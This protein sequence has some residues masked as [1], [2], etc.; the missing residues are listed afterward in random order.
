MNTKDLE[1]GPELDA[2]VAAKVM[3]WKI[4]ADGHAWMDAEL[5][6]M[7]HRESGPWMAAGDEIWSPS[8]D[9]A[10]A[11]EVWL[12]FDIDDDRGE[13]WMGEV[14]KGAVTIEHFPKG[15][16]GKLEIGRGDW[17]VTA[18]YPLAV[19]RAALKAVGA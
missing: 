1:G 5:R 13:L 7:A 14:R 3:G 8:A 9:I 12:A 11:T 6:W 2:L 15:F 4:S 18:L 10:D 19:C 17:R 16:I